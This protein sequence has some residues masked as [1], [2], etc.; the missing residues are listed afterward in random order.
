[1]A[2]IRIMTDSAS[3]IPAE[4]QKS[5]G[6]EVLPFIIAM[7]DREYRDNVDFTPVEFY[8]K[9]EASATVPTH[10]QLTPFTFLECYERAFAEGC[11]DLIYVSINAGGSATNQNAMI[12]RDAFFRDHPE[13]GGKF[14]VHVVD[15][16]TYTMGYGYAAVLGARAA[17]EGKSVE[18]VLTVIRDWIDHQRVLFV[19]YNLQFVKKSGRVSA[20][21]A[22]IG[23]A[24]G[25]RPLIGFEDGGAKILGKVRGDK[26]VVPAIVDMMKDEMEPGSEYLCIHGAL[27][28]RNDELNAE[29]REKLGYL[30]VLSY[31]LGCII[32]INCGPNVV[33][34]VYRKKK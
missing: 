21:A 25:L 26:A 33:A 27:E 18:E 17:A 9:L 10:S 13:A 31:Y 32:A 23:D 22:F 6:I 7:D 3:D 19:P 28:D 30:P 29:C 15:G 16:T 2:K 4:L 12:A 20:A 1:M 34:L 14:S 5:C 8:R 24:L 11:T